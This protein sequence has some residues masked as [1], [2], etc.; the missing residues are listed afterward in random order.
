VNCR[1]AQAVL[2]S[3]LVLA[4][5]CFSTVGTA[6]ADDLFTLTDGSNVVSFQLPSNPSVSGWNDGTN[7]G[8][9]TCNSDLTEF[10]ILGVTVM[11]DGSPQ[12]SQIEFFNIDSSGG[13][14]ILAPDGTEYTLNQAGVQLYTGDESSPAFLTG[15]FPLTNTTS[16]MFPNDYSSDFTLT[17]TPTP[18]PASLMLLGSGVLA[19]A[20]RM[21]RK[22][23]G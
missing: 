7:S 10:C 16:G 23:R 18:E 20:G 8:G 9:V 22:I 2:L 12:S 19:L 14:A 3:T 17:I 1:R 5:L 13:L 11:N 15:V 21:R 4:V 6:K